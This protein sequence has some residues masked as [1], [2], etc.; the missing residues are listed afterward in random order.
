MKD[1]QPGK[2]QKAVKGTL[3]PADHA[4]IRDENGCYFVFFFSAIQLAKDETR[5]HILHISAE[6]TDI[7]H[8]IL[9]LADAA[10]LPKYVHHLH[11]TSEVM[12]HWAIVLN[13]TRP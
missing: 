4:R 8:N 10:L 11:F 3:E 7:I 5:L 9:P 1:H 2:D 13:A 12:Q 6:R